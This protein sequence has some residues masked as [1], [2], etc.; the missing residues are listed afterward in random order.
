MSSS[1]LRPSTTTRAAGTGALTAV[2]PLR[3]GVNNVAITVRASSNS[4]SIYRVAITR[5]KP[6]LGDNGLSVGI[7]NGSDNPNQTGF[8]AQ[9]LTRPDGLTG[10]N[11]A[12]TTY[13]VTLDYAVTSTVVQSTVA[14]PVTMEVGITSRIAPSTTTRENPTA[15]QYNAIVPLG[16][17]DNRIQIKVSGKGRSNEYQTY[18][19]NVKRNRPMLTGLVVEANPGDTAFGT[20][21][22][23]VTGS[24]VTYSRFGPQMA[25]TT[26]AGWL[27]GNPDNLGFRQGPNTTTDYMTSVEYSRSRIRVNPTPGPSVEVEYIGSRDADTDT[28][29]YDM[30]LRPGVN[31]VTIR[32]RGMGASNRQY[33]T[34]YDL[35]ITRE[36]T[37]LNSMGVSATTGMQPALDPEFDMGITDYEAM[38]DYIATDVTITAGATTGSEIEFK[39]N[40]SVV[41]TTAGTGTY[42]GAESVAT[43]DLSEMMALPVGDNDLELMVSI[44]GDPNTNPNTYS[45]TLRRKEPAPT[46]WFELLDEDGD[47]LSVDE[48]Q[49]DLTS[50]DEPYTLDEDDGFTV[51]VHSVKI[52][53]NLNGASEDDVNITL[54]R[55]EIPTTDTDGVGDRF[56]THRLVPGNNSLPFDVE[57]RV[58]PESDA[59]TFSESRHEVTIDRTGNSVPTFRANHHLD[60]APHDV[61]HNEQIE[62]SEQAIVLPY[63]TGGNGRLEYR[64]VGI[65]ADGTDGPLPQGLS[66]DLPGDRQD[67]QVTGS[68]RILNDSDRAYQDLRWIVNDTDQVTGSADES[69]IDFTIVIYRDEAARDRAT[70][71]GAPAPGELIDLRVLHVDEYVEGDNRHCDANDEA[72]GD[73]GTRDCADLTPSFNGGRMSYTATVPTDIATVDIHAVA[74]SSATVTLRGVAGTQNDLQTSATPGEAGATRH[75]WNGHRIRN[76]GSTE[77]DYVITVT[78]GTVVNEYNLTVVR[79]RDTRPVLPSD[80]KVTYRFFEGTMVD[81]KLDSASGG[82][83][84]ETLWTYSISRRSDRA[85]ESTMYLGLTFNTTTDDM[86][87]ADTVFDDDVQGRL[88]GRANLDTA[89]EADSRLSDRSEVWASYGVSDADDNTEASDK[90]SQDIDI[91]VYRDVRLSSYQVGN[92]LV[93]DL[94]M[95]TEDI[96]SDWDDEGDRSEW[97]Y[98]YSDVSEYVYTGLAYDAN[99][100][101]FRAVANNGAATVQIMNADADTNAAGHQI[102]LTARNNPVTVKVTNGTMYATHVIN[103]T[104]PGLFLSK[105]E[106]QEDEGSMDPGKV[107]FPTT[108]NKFDATGDMFMVDAPLWLE[109]VKIFADA[110]D[111]RASVSVDG[112]KKP[113]AGFWEADLEAAGMDTTFVITVSMGATVATQE[114]ATTTLVISRASDSAPAFDMDMV[115]MA[116]KYEVGK[117]LSLELPTATGG[118]GDLTYS[119]NEEELPPGLEFVDATDDDAP[120]I[121]G[122]PT[123]SQGYESEFDLIYKVT[124]QDANTAASDMDEI[125]FT[126]V[127]THEPQPAD[128]N[129]EN[130]FGPGEDFN[131]LDSINVTFTQ[132]SRVDVA[133]PLSPAFDPTVTA[134]TVR[135]PHDAS[136]TEISATPSHTG[137]GLRINRIR[138]SSG[139]RVILQPVTT[140]RV[141]P[142]ASSGLSDMV[143]TVT[144]AQTTDT[145]PS[146]DGVD[147]G[148]K[149]YI[150]GEAISEMLP[151]ANGGNGTIAYELVDHENALPK[152]LRF[153]AATRELAGTPLLVDDADDTL[154]RMTYTATDENGDSDMVNFTIRICPSEADCTPTM[155][156]PNP[157]QTPID[158]MVTR[159]S[160]G[161][162]ATLTWTPGDDAASQAVLAIDPSDMLASALATF[163]ELG[164]DADRATISGLTA[165]VDYIYIVAGFDANGNHKDASGNLYFA[166]YVEGN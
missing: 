154:Y 163:A 101:T 150:A 17:G 43:T 119:I 98:G 96:P 47:P 149:V 121:S 22:T 90:D 63:A 34:D 52:A 66:Y 126:I 148:D 151:A 73:I 132:G 103:L 114:V 8:T 166:R 137:S 53:V 111:S 33:W 46:L 100:V 2:V 11:A 56:V 51:D 123:L 13:E 75:E 87:T 133:A 145:S 45:V 79:V 136:N 32:A 42:T 138:V 89:G 102:A 41:T 93:E 6:V 112:I 152:G 91:I 82:N 156:V 85:P 115:T 159:S 25:S 29:V 20:D 125:A 88:S 27:T 116:D 7:N 80:D 31:T 62:G 35:E 144:M 48:V 69:S 60:S 4:Y 70:R 74:T 64:L 76:G 39:L 140:I 127:I 142:P 165:G 113:S 107:L 68:P 124:D 158:L 84:P 94:A 44:A 83:G 72:N 160:D 18:E 157:G 23:S 14:D 139:D 21:P 110:K 15:G 161:M 146:F 117:A 57:F 78:E 155:P 104:R 40:G 99:N 147:V 128:S 106:V 164:G 141:V 49:L 65:E 26:L 19:V 55:V 50:S 92:D 5:A 38:V 54:G 16:V 3:V 143:Y 122:T 37:P 58:D 86:D 95:A 67:G 131:T 129:G 108:T 30:N 81:E 97:Q 10:F 28:G 1:P 134:Y 153:D 36:R 12:S 105:L 77:N 109:T 118:N 24:P 59:D 130:G 71:P 61:F 120:M 135:I 162:S 9:T